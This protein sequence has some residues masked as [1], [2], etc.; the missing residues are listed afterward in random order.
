[1]GIP[2]WVHGLLAAGTTTIVAALLFGWGRARAARLAARGPLRVAANARPPT[3]AAPATIAF[4]GDVQKGVR[5]VARPVAEAIARE[6]AAFLVSSGDLSSHGDAPYHG[7]VTHAFERAGLD[8][9]FLV[10][11]GN[12][13]L[14]SRRSRDNEPGRRRF[15][16]LWGPRDFAASVG[17]LLLLGCD[18]GGANLDAAQIDWIER[19]LAAHP[20]GPWLLVIHRPPLDLSGDVPASPP[21]GDRLLALLARRPPEC[22]VSGHLERDADRVVGGVRYVVNA[23]G[24]D[25][26]GDPWRG[27]ATFRLLLVD[28]A[29]DGRTRLRR[30]ELA[31]RRDRSIALDQLAVRLWAD[32]R[33]G[34]LR[35][36]GALG[37]LLVRP[38]VRSG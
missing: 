21:P 16:A 20:A 32:A 30:V 15:E 3:I 8:V 7:I 14:Q 28:V 6:R 19:A 12:H 23:E 34:P 22:V 27:P 25:V 37:D 29:A 36:L 4:L 13:D 17:P 35:V 31:R 18:N 26:S 24:G 38:F 1:V 9:P 2:L 33:R 10:V 5:A 11:P